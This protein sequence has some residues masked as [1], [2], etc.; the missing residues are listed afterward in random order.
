MAT[1][2]PVEFES[3]S[4]EDVYRFR[5]KLE[6]LSPL[7]M[8]HPRGMDKEEGKETLRAARKAKAPSREEEAAERL[9]LD[10]SGA[11]YVPVLAIGRSLIEAGKLFQDPDNKRARMSKMLAAGIYMPE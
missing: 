4:A 8:S 7:L 3:S 10:A 9:Y 11:L 1:I 5:A 6:G 2:D